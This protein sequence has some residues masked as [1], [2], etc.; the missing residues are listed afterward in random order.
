VRFYPASLLITAAVFLPNLLLLALPP[1]NVRKYGKSSDSLAFTIIERA[2]QVSC[3]ILPL[4]F[5]LSF[6]GSL[7]I[8]AWIVMGVSLGFYYAGWIRFFVQ[9]RD[10]SLLYRPMIGLPVPLAISPVIYFL[11]ASL[12]LGSVYQAIAALVLGVGHISIS[13]HESHR[14]GAGLPPRRHS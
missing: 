2:G 4:L 10:Y 5:S 7:V 3:F 13:I 14:I 6:T 12:V 1:L 8:A 11:F 9:G